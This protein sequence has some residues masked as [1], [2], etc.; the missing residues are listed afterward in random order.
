MGL[1]M[2]TY[3]HVFGDLG[4]YRVLVDSALPTIPVDIVELLFESV[5]AFD[6]E[7]LREGC[8]ALYQNKNEAARLVRTILGAL[9]ILAGSI[10]SETTCISHHFAF[11]YAIHVIESDPSIAQFAMQGAKGFHRAF[12]SNLMDS[13][14]DFTNSAKYSRLKYVAASLPFHM[15]SGEMLLRLVICLPIGD[16]ASV[17]CSVG[18]VTAVRLQIQDV[19]NLLER[20]VPGLPEARAQS[21]PYY[22]L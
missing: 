6:E 5:L 10:S 19:E 14:H 15:I 2:V 1:C 20:L 13:A 4:N 3:V 12:A 7:T 8:A 16:F 17:E 18:L 21:R 11:D 9:G 22:H